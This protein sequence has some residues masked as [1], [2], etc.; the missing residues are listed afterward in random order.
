MEDEN[1]T[2]PKSKGEEKARSVLE[3]AKITAERIEK[4]NIQTEKLLQ[5]IQE[6]EAFRAIGGK[7]S[8]KPQEV[9]KV[10]L[11][12]REYAKAALAGKIIPKE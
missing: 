11:D 7:S 2:K 9:P 3:D 1:E 5:Q 6:I 10:E 8:G 12:P 4:A